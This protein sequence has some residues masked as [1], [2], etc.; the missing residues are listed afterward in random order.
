MYVKL[1]YCLPK[2]ISKQFQS[3][4][5]NTGLKLGKTVWFFFVKYA[6]HLEMSVLKWQLNRESNNTEIKLVWTGAASFCLTFP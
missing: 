3:Q 6:R 2:N 1:L 4:Q 5:I